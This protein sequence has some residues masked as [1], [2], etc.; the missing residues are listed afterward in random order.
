MNTATPNGGRKSGR[1]TAAAA[2]A[3]KQITKI[4]YVLTADKLPISTF[5]CNVKHRH[6]QRQLVCLSFFLLF[7]N[8]SRV[9][10]L[11]LIQEGQI[12]IL[13][14][15]HGNK[16]RYGV[17]GLTSPKNFQPR[18]FF[19]SLCSV[20][21]NTCYLFYSRR[22]CLPSSSSHHLRCLSIFASFNSVHV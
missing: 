4:Y 13:T 17:R 21:T 3:N 8:S 19:F 16:E 7:V 10:V 2:T 12:R 1:T 9:R 5:I 6:Q 15:E 20:Y 14:T 11:M 22:E 18:A